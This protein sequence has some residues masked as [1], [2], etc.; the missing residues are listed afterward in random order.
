V[1]PEHKIVMRIM[2]V[3]S[4]V[5]VISFILGVGFFFMFGSLALPNGQ[6]PDKLNASVPSTVAID[7]M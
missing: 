7:V 1:V 2:L 6:L 3:R 5:V 4:N